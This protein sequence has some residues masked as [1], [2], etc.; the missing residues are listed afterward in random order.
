MKDVQ[1]PLPLPFRLPKEAGCGCG[2]GCGN[3]SHESGATPNLPGTPP[4]ASFRLLG[5]AVS[6]TSRPSGLGS[7]FFSL[8]S[9][10]RFRPPCFDA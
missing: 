1:F 9:V 4:Y 7:G 5:R 2:C 8:H 6:V 3:V 10:A